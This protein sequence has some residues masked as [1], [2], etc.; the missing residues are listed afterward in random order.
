MVTFSRWQPDGGYVYYDA[1]GYTAPLGDDLPDPVMPLP[2]KLGVPSIEIGH[3]L[4]M[5]ARRIGEGQLPRG[6][7]APMDTSRL[8]SLLPTCA[9]PLTWLLVGGAVAGLV[10]WAL[11]RGRRRGGG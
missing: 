4:P 8:G 5:G 2:T 11:M 3:P 10:T 1:P 7:I 6:V 9:S